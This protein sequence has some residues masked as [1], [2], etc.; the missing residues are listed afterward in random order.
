MRPYE[1]DNKFSINNNVRKAINQLGAVCIGICP[2]SIDNIYNSINYDI[3]KDNCHDLINVLK[4]CDGII[5]QGG[6]DYYEYDK[7]IL[8]YCIDNDVP[9]LGIC[10]GMQIMASLYQDNLFK[11]N[12]NEHYKPGV[13]YVHD[14]NID[15]NSKLFNIVSTDN[16]KVNSRHKEAIGNS[17]I[18]TVSGRSN[19][20]VIEA[21]EYNKNTFN[22]GLAWHVEDL[23][24]NPENRKILHQFLLIS[25]N[26]KRIR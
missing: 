22:I 11:L 13:K 16:L 18:Y 7:F 24:F 12:N 9:V 19:D 6:T 21:I 1:N 26:K 4:L 2:C 5:L 3:K 15:V 20:G 14:V 25:K 10:L 17:G 23:I 8:K